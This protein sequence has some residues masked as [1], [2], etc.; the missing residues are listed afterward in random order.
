MSLRTNVN[1]FIN[2]F[3]ILMCCLILVLTS[4][5]VMEVQSDS[6]LKSIFTLYVWLSYSF[7]YLLPT[8]IVAKVLGLIND[9]FPLKSHRQW[10]NLLILSTILL[11]SIAT[12]LF[13]Y[14]DYYIFNLYGYH[15]DAFVINLIKTPGGI[16]SLGVT[17]STIVTIVV[18][19]IV[20]IAVVGGLF[21]FLYQQVVVK[22]KIF[23]LAKININKILFIFFILFIVEEFSHGALAAMGKLDVIQASSSLPLNL[24]TTFNSFVKKLGYQPASSVKKMA[25]GKVQYPLS[26]IS[27]KKIEKPLNIIWLVA[28]SLRWDMLSPEIMPKYGSFRKIICALIIIIVVATVPEWECLP[29]SMACMRLI[30]IHLKHKE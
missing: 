22:E 19:I 14:S 15:I 20:I 9:R 23:F 2:A 18:Q 28:E 5:F 29:C 21:Y 4:K 17:N 24:N 12:F 13:L 3:L 8:I 26:P 16:E 11:A 7:L 1:Y 30:G 6:L 27:Y 25:N 10:S